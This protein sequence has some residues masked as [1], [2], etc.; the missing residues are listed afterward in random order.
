MKW[1][2]EMFLQM[3]GVKRHDSASKDNVLELQWAPDLDSDLR[4]RGKLDLDG[5]QLGIQHEFHQALAGLVNYG[6]TL[7]ENSNP[8]NFKFLKAGMGFFCAGL[9]DL[10]FNYP[11][12]ALQ[13]DGLAK[14]ELARSKGILAALENY[15]ERYQLWESKTSEFT[16]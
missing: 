1:Q 16:L 15:P 7:P 8:I 2:N 9:Y 12:T 11:F 4:I 5:V 14:I 13:N 3:Y 6:Q 10:D